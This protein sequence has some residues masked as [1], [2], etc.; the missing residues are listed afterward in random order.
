[1]AEESDDS[2][3]DEAN[4]HVDDHTEEDKG[5]QPVSSEVFMLFMLSLPS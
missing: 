3:C 4:L 2:V 1:M 5:W